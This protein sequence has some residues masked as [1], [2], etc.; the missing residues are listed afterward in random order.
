MRKVYQCS[1]W[2]VFGLCSGSI[3]TVGTLIHLHQSIRNTC[4][5]LHVKTQWSK[6]IS[7]SLNKRVNHDRGQGDGVLT[8]IYN[9][10]EFDDYI[11][12]SRTGSVN[13]VSRT[14]PS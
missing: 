13:D 2:A 14:Q 7:K 9:F 4:I 3:I 12:H 5:N 8:I 10:G 11:Q 1:Q 6:H